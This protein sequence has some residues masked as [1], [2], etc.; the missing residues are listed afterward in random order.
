MTVAAAINGQISSK[1]PALF[2]MRYAAALGRVLELLHVK[3]DKDDLEE[4]ESSMDDIEQAATDCGL[5]VRR[6]FL[7]GEPAEKKNYLTEYL[8]Q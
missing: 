3:N 5:V 4:V 1:G 7:E 2:A 8:R 6:L